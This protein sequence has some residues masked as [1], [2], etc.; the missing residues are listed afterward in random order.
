[1]AGL[2]LPW[3]RAGS[4][5]AST[6][7]TPGVRA[8]SAAGSSVL[9]W[10]AVAIIVV[11][12]LAARL[13]NANWD[14]NNHLHPDER[15][16]TI[17]ANDV[18][19]PSSL[20]EYFDSRNSP[21]NPYNRM[22]GGSFVYG[23]LPLFLVKGTAQFLDRD[24]YDGLTLTGRQLS[25]V[26]SA[27]TV[28]LTF[29][30][31]RRLYG[32]VAGLLAAVLMASAPLAI[33]HAHFFVV[34]PFMTFFTTA[35]LYFAVRASQTGRPE[36]F[37]L[38]GLMLGLGMACKVTALLFA[39]VLAAAAVLH[40]WPELQ[41]A[42]STRS[43]ADLVRA[44]TVP[45]I[46]L[47]AAG[48]VAFLAFRVAQPYAFEPPRLLNLA[49]WTIELDGR[50]VQDQQAQS[51]LLGG[52]AAFPPS[53]QWIG[54]TSY[55]FPLKQMIQWGM[56]PA[57]GI[58]GWAGA[59]YALYRFG[60][61][62]DP[63]GVL[64]LLFIALYFGFMGRQFSLYLRYFLPLYP[65]LAVFAGHLLVD[66]VGAATRLGEGRKLPQLRN[67]A[68]A[69]VGLVVALGVLAGLA[70]LSI[71][72]RPITRIEASQWARA[73]IPAGSTIAVE[74]WDD[75]VPGHSENVYT[76]VDLPMYEADS[77][78]KILTLVNALD[79]AQYIS[80]SSN[81][82]MNSI[83]RNR[84]TYPV[85]A[86]YYELLLSGDLGFRVA[87]EF[88]SYPGLL[89]LSIPDHGTEES[90]SSYDHPRVL[91]FEKTPVYSR[92]RVVALLDPNKA[93]SAV[94]LLPGDAGTNALLL[95]PD[96]LARQR[97]GGTWTDVFASGGIAHSYPAL[98]WFGAI[99]LAAF[100]V[101]PVCLLLFRRLPDRGYL[102]SKPLGM[103]LLAYPVW[104]AVS[105][106]LVHF[107]QTTILVWLLLMLVAG[108][109]LAVRFSDELRS[110]LEGR[111]H[112]VLI[113]EAVFILAFLLF[114]NF[115]LVNPD[116]WHPFRGG[117]KPM[118]LAYLTATIRSTTL[119]PYDP[120]FAGGYINY[121]Y[122]GQFFTATVAKLTRIVPEVAFNLAIPTFFAM[123]V[124]GAFS[125]TYNLAEATRALLKRR[126]GFRPLSPGSTVAAALLGAVFV[127]IL[128][129]L[130]GVGQMVERLSAVS[131]WKVE[132]GIPLIAPIANS[133]GGLWQ[134]VVHGAELRDFD[135][136]RP[137]RMMPPTISIT[138]FPYF[139]FLFADLHAHMMAMP[140]S[141]L[142]IG[143][144]LA[145]ALGIAGER[146]AWREWL[147]VALVGLIVGSLR[148]LNSW[149]YPPFLLLAVAA[150]VIGERRLEGTLARS[151]VR[152]AGKTLLLVGLSF[153]LYY[154]FLANY[155]QP[156]S[157]LIAAPETTP[158][159]QYLAHFGV[160]L[161]A[162]A[163]WL[164]YQ[165]IRSVRSDP[166][167]VVVRRGRKGGPAE[168]WR[169]YEGLPSLSQ[170]WVSAM[171]T[172]TGVAIALAFLYAVRGDTVIAA[173]IPVLAVVTYL[174]LR[175]LGSRRP[176]AGVRLFV[177]AM[178]GLAFGL[179]LSVDLV[180][181][182]GDIQRMNTVF[183]FYLHIWMLLGMVAAF[184]AWYLLFVAW[185]PSLPR[186]TREPLRLLPRHVGGAGLILLVL[187][188]F[189]YPLMATPVR[190]N[191]RFVKTPRTLD[192]MAY[193][194]SAVYGDAKGPIALKPDYDGIQW[195]RQ[196]VEGTPTI[197]EGH[198]PELYRWGAR[199]SIYTGLPTVLGWDWHQ[200][201]QRGQFGGPII[202]R[203]AQQVR[204][205]YSNPDAAQAIRFLSQYDVRYVIVGQL[206]ALYF[207]Q[208]GLAKFAAGL[209]GTLEVAYQNANLT[210]YRVKLSQ[211]DL[212][213]KALP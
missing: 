2:R 208:A 28:L 203:R 41:R 12:A 1:M 110:S 158:L 74:H 111:W 130:D 38:G 37:I 35:V 91:F 54:R 60:R 202:D 118:D 44:A 129:N 124:A 204:E 200:K 121:Y 155:H 147:L 51:R 211:Y 175:E 205:F 104:L 67:A 94:H 151:G 199:F 69:A 116:L 11:L 53:V 39:P 153:L 163:A 209:D 160:F 61:L 30:V 27:L 25:A 119:P 33:Q 18:R 212:A 213:L 92:E 128:G 7:A 115:R 81:R 134:V 22:A 10:S 179:S 59:V 137:S 62:R 58:A 14:S 26:F 16:L 36:D 13:Y 109:Y 159:H 173:M 78:Q 197:V 201:Q 47:A 169:T 187:A 93:G 96:D 135:F 138:E 5:S 146:G 136:W 177:L 189:I 84:V 64:P 132:S 89:G 167:G 55:L 192:G 86:R 188:G 85:S 171:L 117:E 149:D 105:L 63:R 122:L 165:L 106:K 181:I 210:I 172:V 180:T 100:A 133:I 43:T 196:N 90:W 108:T 178:L 127:A 56:G 174:A 3:R 131:A 79:A 195:L 194:Q 176:D 150:I 141:I 113:G 114:Y 148:W 76:F 6:A 82:L 66:A 142:A 190:L 103:L 166:G 29:L 40:L 164:L 97:E 34:D 83:P 71:Y 77:P 23:T 95:R 193:M 143:G 73:N 20:A 21:L 4:Q 184:A 186:A 72:T 88:T 52:D 168:A 185:S 31:G 182:K 80:I 140:F 68:V 123:T 125:V 32:P 145:L 70:Y 57:F 101:A 152:V 19:L 198:I 46:G 75:R 107:S 207:D 144:S 17:V 49:P 42:L 183:K 191:E 8:S 156:V 45:V 154:P 126:P 50:W 170:L 112:I 120:W 24:N 206:E 9:V 102:L 65:A 157:G 98:L 87:K 48:L 139:S 15:H 161:A 162:I 99:Q